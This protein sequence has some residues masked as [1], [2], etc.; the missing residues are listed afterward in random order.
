[1]HVLKIAL[2]Y[3]LNSEFVQDWTVQVLKNHTL[4]QIRKKN[5]NIAVLAFGKYEWVKLLLD[6]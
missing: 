6:G 1:M 4:N 3:I 2:L 5:K